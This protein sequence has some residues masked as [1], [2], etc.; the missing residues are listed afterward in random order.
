MSEVPLTISNG[1]WDALPSPHEL[2]YKILVKGKRSKAAKRDGAV[3][4]YWVE[5]SRGFM[6][7][8]RDLVV[9]V[10]HREMRQ[11]DWIV[12]RELS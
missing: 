12:H 6:S 4:G 1:S 2:Q 7:K 10:V 3:S 11:S 9:D 8:R 5:F